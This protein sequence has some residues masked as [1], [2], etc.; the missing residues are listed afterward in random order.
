MK[1]ALCISGQPRHYEIG[2][3]SFTKAILNKYNPDVFIHT[4]YDKDKVGQ[5]YDRSDPAERR[6]ETQNLIYDDI[7]EGINNLY[8]PKVFIH[9]PQV[10]FNLRDTGFTLAEHSITPFRLYSQKYSIEK[11]NDLKS[12]YE[13]ENGFKYDWV[14]RA[15]FDLDYDLMNLDLSKYNKK[16]IYVNGGIFKVKTQFHQ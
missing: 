2:Y 12:E 13:K 8:R 14:I 3:F 9:E 16:Y 4:W 15:R 5:V 6:E 10:Q 11:A 1:I 7:P